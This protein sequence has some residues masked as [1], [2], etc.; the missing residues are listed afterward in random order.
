MARPIKNNAEYFS[1]D[2]D[3]R[4]DVRIKAL[5]RKYGHTGYSVWNMIIEYLTDS[6][7]F[8]FECTEMGIELISADFDVDV[9][10]LNEILE[11]LL[12]LN[13]LQKTDDKISCKTLVKRLEGVIE[14]RVTGRKNYQKGEFLQQKPQNND[15]SETETTQSKVKESKVNKI[16]NNTDN[17]SNFSKSGENFTPPSQIEVYAYFSEKGYVQEAAELF[18]TWAEGLDWVNEKTGQPLKWKST[19]VNW[20]KKEHKKPFVLPSGLPLGQGEEIIDGKRMFAGYEVPME[21]GPR[22]SSIYTFCNI[23]KTWYIQ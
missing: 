17:F 21:L 13:L 8:Q 9:E 18:F 1:H 4:N 7:Y 14:K 3:M 12:K 6:D 15:V 23:S 2:A 16:N 11:Y 22:P 5:R 10:L 20:L 19:A